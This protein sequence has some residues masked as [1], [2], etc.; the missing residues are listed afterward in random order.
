M[1]RA[2]AGSE[3]AAGRL[4]ERH[5]AAVWRTGLAVTG[6]RDLA[7]EV[8]QDA[9][10]RAFRALG[11]FDRRRPLRPWLVTI[12]AHRAVDVLRRERRAA[13]VHPAEVVGEW[14]DGLEQARDLMQAVAALR[15]ERRLV[16]VM[17]YWLD[18]SHQEIAEV[19]GVPVG[20]VASRLGRALEE[21]RTSMEVGD[22]PGA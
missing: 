6:R 13:R 9:F 21:L 7:E 22:V 18:L 4:A 5:W 15:E 17:R 19:L 1:A 12:A 8:A 14:T 10:E 20:T 2:L 3:Q 11:R 16:V